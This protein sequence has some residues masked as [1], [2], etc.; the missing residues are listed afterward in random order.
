MKEKV[1]ILTIAKDTF[2]TLI[3]VTEKPEGYQ[4]Y[5]GQATHV[6]ISKPGWEEE[7]RPFTFSSLPEDPCLQFTIKTYP[8]RDGVTDEMTNLS[9]GDELIIEKAAGAI[10]YQ[11]S[12]VFIAGGAGITPFLA[13]FRDLH[14]KGDLGGN[15]LLYSNSHPDEA[16]CAAELKTRL[17]S[18]CRFFVTEGESGP[19]ENGQ[20][21][22]DIL[23]EEVAKHPYGTYYYIC[24]TSEMTKEIVHILEELGISPAF[25]ITEEY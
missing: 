14:S 4:F 12:G 20:I 8:E 25:I 9:P 6:A 5:P 22:H 17:G 24:G 16:I 18:N 3:I 15:S 10:R 13:I 2:E 1:K 11:G 23:F 7:D 21:D 19:F